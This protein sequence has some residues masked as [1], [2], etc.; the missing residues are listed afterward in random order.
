MTHK[1]ITLHPDDLMKD[2]ANIFETNNFHHIPVVDKGGK[3]VGILSKVEYYKL[4][5]GFTIFNV[6]TANK[7]N[8]DVF[9]ALTVEE[10]MTE[11]V[12]KLFPEDTLEQ[13][14]GYFR[15]NLFHAAPVVNKETK[16]IEGIVTTFDLLNYVFQETELLG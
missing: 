10:V 6:K 2:A 1:V 16:R 3:V 11:H 5:H 15:E 4:Q 13:A 7:F 14:M 8:E 12:A 9:G